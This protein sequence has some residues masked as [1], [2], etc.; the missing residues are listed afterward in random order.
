M[1]GKKKDDHIH[2]SFCGR[3]QEETGPIISGVTG[4]IC[5]ECVDRCKQFVSTGV[6]QV[7][8]E[9]NPSTQLSELPPPKK[10]H[11]MLDQYVIGQDEAKKT[12]AVAIYNHYKRLNHN[13]QKNEVE[14]E[15][16]NILLL[17]PT[18][19]GKTL[20]A[21]TLAKI[22]NVPFAIADATTLT[23]AGYVGDDVENILLRLIQNADY[24]VQKAERGIIF[25]DELDKISRKS[26]N[27]SITRDV[28]GE[29][30]QQALLKIIEG[31]TATVPSKGG[32]KHPQSN[33]ITIDT[34]HILFIC[35]GAFVEL[36]HIIKQ[37]TKSQSIG[38]NAE[39]VNKNIASS[40]YLNEVGPD[41]LVKFGLIP[42]LIGRLPILCPMSELDDEAMRAILTQPKNALLKQYQAMLKM[43]DVDLVFH[44]ESYDII[45]NQANALKTGARG[46]RSVLEKI[47]LPIMYDAPTSG[48]KQIVIDKAYLD[49]REIELLDIKKK[50]A[51]KLKSKETVKKSRVVAVSKNIA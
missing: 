12:M 35:G 21:S 43:D 10:I 15:K 45:I 51:E 49:K 5:V 33:N 41:D 46:L 1:A 30:V 32:R 40:E 3:S 22:V 27:T 47:M 11:E 13:S 29:G 50:M 26:E 2:C 44:E 8:S 31:T 6:D 9:P 37:R 20:L 19:C 38:F 17:G 28:S 18:G 39:L 42:E 25:I 34:K 23:E 7:L 4:Y 24:D 14:L 16:S 36:D 48:K